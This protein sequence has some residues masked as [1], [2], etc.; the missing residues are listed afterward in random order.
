MSK[1]GEQILQIIL[2]SREHP[3]AEHI[4]MEMKNNNSKVVQ[5]TVYN[6]LKTLLQEGKIIRI[7]EPG[8]PDRY[9]NTT[10]HDHIICSRCGKLADI[11]L[12][13]MTESIEKQLGYEIESYELKVRYICRDCKKAESYQTQYA[14]TQN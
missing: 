13:D 6:N 11:R 8:C 9:D 7:T 2:N 10:R 12:E 1:Y 14:G 3:T 4:F 5:A